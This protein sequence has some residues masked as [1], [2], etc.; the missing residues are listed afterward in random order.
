VPN[1][2]GPPVPL[3]SR[4]IHMGSRGPSA[5]NSFA[6]SHSETHKTPKSLTVFKSNDVPFFFFQTLEKDSWT[7]N[8]N[9]RLKE[10]EELPI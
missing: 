8:L 6:C 10:Y 1:A 7:K 2:T 3:K 5:R 4:K 9:F